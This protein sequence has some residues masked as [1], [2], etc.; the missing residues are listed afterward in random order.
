MIN[1]IEEFRELVKIYGI[2]KERVIKDVFYF[3]NPQ[4]EDKFIER[5]NKK[6]L[7]LK[8]VISNNFGV[9]L[10]Y[11]VKIDKDNEY[12]IQYGISVVSPEDLNKTQNSTFR[13]IIEDSLERKTK[14]FEFEKERSK[15]ADLLYE[16]I[17]KESLTFNT[18]FYSNF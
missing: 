18:P 5:E 1:I 16:K 6:Y 10:S 2:D 14:A 9:L 7:I 12:R 3:T 17:L 15:K 8:A 4:K 11:M 13:S